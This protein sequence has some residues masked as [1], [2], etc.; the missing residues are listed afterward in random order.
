ML[1][2]E[3]DSFFH[4]KLMTVRPHMVQE[5]IEGSKP[6]VE[7]FAHVGAHS[8]DTLLFLSGPSRLATTMIPHVKAIYHVVLDVLKALT[9]P[10]IDK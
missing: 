4:P 6:G 5:E 8:L 10:G 7:R 3:E 9:V 2:V 1:I